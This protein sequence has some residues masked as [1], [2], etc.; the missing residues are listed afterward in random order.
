[1]GRARKSLV[2]KLLRAADSPLFELPKSWHVLSRLVHLL[3]HSG[4][5]PGVQPHAGLAAI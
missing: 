2:Q 3:L 1:M 4:P 5:S